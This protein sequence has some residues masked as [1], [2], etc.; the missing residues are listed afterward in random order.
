MLDDWYTIRLSRLQEE[1]EKLREVAHVSP[2][3]AKKA[4]IEMG[5]K[6]TGETNGSKTCTLK[7]EEG[8]VETEAEDSTR[9]AVISKFLV[10]MPDDFYQFWDLCF[11][12]NPSY[13]HCKC[14]SILCVAFF[15]MFKTSFLIT[16][17]MCVQWH[18]KIHWGWNWWVLIMF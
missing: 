1:E 14:L 18:W 16:I 9:S 8:K 17:A 5:M 4:R 6:K 13:P 12:L 11:T 3:P 2:P 7:E 10:S 15:I